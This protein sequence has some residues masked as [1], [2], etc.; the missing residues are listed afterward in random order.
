VELMETALRVALKNTDKL[1][2]LNS[3]DPKTNLLYK[4]VA[5]VA[6]AAQNGPDPRHLMD[7][8]VFTEIVRRILP[9]VSAN[10]EPLLGGNVQPVKDAVLT[11]LRLAGSALE[12]RINGA[13]LP[14]LV[15]G[16]LRGILLKDLSLDDVDAVATTADGLLRL[17]A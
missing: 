1:L 15:E 14:Q 2:D 17:A 16:L 12:N 6:D 10:I 7:R 4:V 13:N 5:A 9:V 3:A 8:D 11:A